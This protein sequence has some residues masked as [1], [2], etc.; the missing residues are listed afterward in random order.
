MRGTAAASGGADGFCWRIGAGEGAAAR[1]RHP[2]RR[3][4]AHAAGRALVPPPPRRA[5][6]R[7]GSLAGLYPPTGGAI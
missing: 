1:R 7:P 2:A 6:R 5:A 3:R 4:P